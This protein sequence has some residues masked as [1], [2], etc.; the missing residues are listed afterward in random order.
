MNFKKWITA[1]LFC[2]LAIAPW[3][4][5]ESPVVK[6]EAAQVSA[7]PAPRSDSWYEGADGYVKASKEFKQ[8]HRPMVVYFY[9]SWCP[10]CRRFEKRVLS[11]PQVQEF[12][13]DKIKVR[14]NPEAGDRENSLAFRYEINGFPAF[15]LHPAQSESAIQLP[16]GVSADQFIQI[17]EQASQ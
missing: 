1:L 6:Q 15:F 7:V 13:K 17:F 3:V 14:I 5:A 9:A 10:Y 4:C 11:S 16:T 2:F 12:L 8:T